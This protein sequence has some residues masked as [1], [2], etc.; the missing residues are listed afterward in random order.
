MGERGVAVSRDALGQASR[1]GSRPGVPCSSEFPHPQL[2]RDESASR[3]RLLLGVWHFPCCVGMQGHSRVIAFGPSSELWHGCS[4]PVAIV[5]GAD[6]RGDGIVSTP[7]DWG[8]RVGPTVGR[9]RASE[10]GGSVMNFVDRMGHSPCSEDPGAGWS[11]RRALNDVSMSGW[12]HVAAPASGFCS[13]DGMQ[14][15]SAR[16]VAD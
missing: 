8:I 2:E 4:C 9:Y 11:G 14:Q 12:R 15:P 6:D 10:P 3:C 1:S 13:R 5:A 7:A 16:Q